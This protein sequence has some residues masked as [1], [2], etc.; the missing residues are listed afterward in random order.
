M[1]GMFNAPGPMLRGPSDILAGL[2]YIAQ[3]TAFPHFDGYP[4]PVKATVIAQ[5]G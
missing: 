3:M 4:E 2:V 1:G 5:K